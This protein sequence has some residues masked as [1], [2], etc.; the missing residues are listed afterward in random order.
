MQQLKTLLLV[1]I[2]C[3]AFT[4]LSALN[5]PPLNDT[6]CDATDLGVLPIPGLC[7]TY[8]YGDTIMVNGTTDW[9]SYNTF[10]FSPAS[11]FPGGAPDVWYRFR[12]TG[13][14]LYM[15]M[16]GYN[17]LDSF[18]V[19][20]Y[21][22]QGSCL[23]LVPL[24]CEITYTGF[25]QVAFLTPEVGGE[26]YLQI[27]GSMYDETGNFSFHMKSYNE[28]NGCVKN[29]SLE[30]SPAPWFGRY[31]TNDTVQMCVTVE[32]WDQTT[33][34]NVHGI[35]PI[36]GDEWDTLTLTPVNTPG[37]GWAWM[38]D[39]PTPQ[40]IHDGFFYDPD[41]NGNPTTNA[42]DTGTITTSW[43]ACWSISTKSYCNAYDASVE[44]YIFSDNLTGT[45]N[46]SS[47][48]Q[49]YWPIH[50]G[51]SG[52][53]CP[54]P[55]VS[56]QPNAPCDSLW[57]ISVDPVSSTADTFNIV[58]YDDSMHVAAYAPNVVTTGFSGVP[59][60]DYLLEV[61]NINTTCISF[62]QV[63][64]PGRFEIDLTQTAIGCGP[65]TAAVE[66][67]PVGGSAP[68]AYSWPG[69]TFFNDSTAYNLDEGYV[70][71]EITD[72]GG[73]MLTDS[74]YVMVMATPGAEFGYEDISYCH[75]HDT[76]QV[77]Y[78]PL[79][80]G[81][82]YQ[83]VSPLSTPITV[84]AVTGT[85]S[86]NG[87]P[88]STPYWIKV[89][90][91]VGSVCTAVHTDS[92]KIVQRPAVPVATS[93]VTVEWCI[94]SAAP[95]HTIGIGSGFPFWYDIQ[96]NQSGFGY[97]FTPSLNASTVPG[98]YL[99]GSVFLADLTAGCSSLPTVFSVNAHNY[100][101]FTMGPDVMICPEDT[102]DIAITGASGTYTYLWTPTPTVGP[103][104][105]AST[106]TSPETSTTYTCVV[107]D[108]ICSVQSTVTVK[109]DSSV[110]CGTAMY[111]GI[112][113]NGDGYNDVWIIES[114][115]GNTGLIVTVYNR[116]GQQVWRSNNYDNSVV[117]FKGRNGQD[118]E[119]PEGTYYYTIEQG[120]RSAE[121]GWLEISR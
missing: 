78:D 86:L 98:T 73:C 76:M 100:P 77:W 41:G 97:S 4:E 106:S 71:V 33:S 96:T 113:P 109:V 46:S 12:A 50:M 3:S 57:I 13:S 19:K 43:E 94:G 59:T 93:P 70:V 48:C 66:A 40:G 80:P 30:L 44:V 89:Q 2:F 74:L 18:F 47:A 108:G 99:Y 82:T 52:W 36:F 54:D 83:L 1:L 85:I 121:K 55:V 39:V 84:D 17:D 88:L 53:C 104:N 21:Y 23:S 63:H 110:T 105:A 15:E 90:Y 91:T 6:V 64:L 87:A 22:S 103:D 45:G 75:D 26:Y 60:G 107:T 10:D 118:E 95:V 27:G 120:N 111:T 117:V 79:T 119:L 42:G 25:M 24:H 28:C 34:S 32:R 14:F 69:V 31:G 101:V 16:N 115:Y 112:T 5:P 62:H 58:L 11:C 68:F 8:P 67:S 20:L 114:A 92:V 116:W 7:P 72:A 49:E 61:Y 102:A 35:V 56:V 81:G 51:L 37:A 29:A 65:A 38:Q 9:A